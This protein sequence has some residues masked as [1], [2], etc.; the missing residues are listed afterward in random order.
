[1]LFCILEVFTTSR[2]LLQGNPF[3]S[4]GSKR[5]QSSSLAG[6][7]STGHC[8]N[9]SKKKIREEFSCAACEI[10]ATCE[11]GLNEHI[12]GKK[13]QAKMEELKAN[14]KGAHIGLGKVMNTV[15]EQPLEIKNSSDSVSI[16]SKEDDKTE[17]CDKKTMT[18]KK[19]R[20]WCRL[21]KIGVDNENI[22]RSHKKGKKHL[23]NRLKKE[24]EKTKR[25]R[26]KS[27]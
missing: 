2:Y 9:S 8:S 25:A 5:K 16:G 20:F 22:M 10:S 12:A 26:S 18:G 6:S 3:L 21:C 19:F 14:K 11:R 1:M 13:H 7:G 15:N 17:V 23:K 4:S 24:R 27:N